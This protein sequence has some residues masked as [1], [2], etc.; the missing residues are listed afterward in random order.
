MTN[1]RKPFRINVGFIIHE[2]VGYS[3]EIPFDIEK[4]KI[5]DLELENLTG[6][7]IIDRTPQGLFVRSLPQGIQ[8]P[9]G[10]AI[11]RTV[12]LQA[13]G[14]QRVRLDSCGRCTY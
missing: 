5:E 12:C 10:V 9:V 7:V 3:H 8:I 4:V 1:P 6:S 13:K 14:R 2:E 11:L